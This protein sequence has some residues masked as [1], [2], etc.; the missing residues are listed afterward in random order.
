MF[1]MDLLNEYN[2]SSEYIDLS[3]RNLI[4]VQGLEKFTNVK[5]L[6][7]SGNLLTDYTFLHHL[8]N[9]T[10]LDLSFNQFKTIELNSPY[11]K[12]I[13]LRGNCLS[14]IQFQIGRAS[15]RERE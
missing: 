7:L 12:S 11:I 5:R 4:S 14:S 8:K 10:H 13:N 1:T 6:N 3:N 9:L 15:C 2:I